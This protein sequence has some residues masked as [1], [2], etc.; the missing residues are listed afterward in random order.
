MARLQID[1]PA[2]LDKGAQVASHYGVAYYPTTILVDAQ[3]VVRAVWV[4][5]AGVRAISAG[6]AG[7]RAISAGVARGRRLKPRLDGLRAA[8]SAC[9]DWQPGSDLRRQVLWRPA[10]RL[11]ARFQPPRRATSAAHALSRPLLSARP[12]RLTSGACYTEAA[13]ALCRRAVVSAGGGRGVCRM[14]SALPGAGHAAPRIFISHSHEDADFCLKL[15]ADLRARLGDDAVWYDASGGQH[16]LQGG[17]AWWDQIVAEIT[18]RPYFLVVLSPHASASRWVP[19]EMGIAFRQHVELGKRLLPVRLAEAPRRA[20]WAGIQEFSFVAPR[21]YE[22]AL[23]DLLQALNVDPQQQAAPPSASVPAPAVAPALTPQQALLRRLTQEAHTAYGRERWS[24]TLDRT[25]ALIARQ[26]MTP[27]LWRERAS[28]ALAL[29]DSQAALNAVGQAL[30]DD[31]DDIETLRLHARI[32]LRAGQ[33][34]RAVE[35]LT[36]ANTL[37][38]LDDAATRLPLLAE[39]CD[40]LERLSRWGDLLRRCG[41]ALYLAP[42]DLAWQR[43]RLAALLGLNQTA[44]A[45]SAAQ[46]LAARAD[47]TTADHLALARLLKSSGAPEA[48]IRSA[49]DAATR[50]S[51]ADPAAAQALAQARGELLAPPPP[52]IPAERFPARLAALGFSAQARDGVEWIIP[53][54]C[55][56]PAGQFRLGSD[57][58]RDKDARDSDELQRRVVDL[59]AFEIARFPVTVAEY[60]CFLTA[61]QRTPPPKGQYNALTWEDQLQRLDHPVV[62]VT[63][64]DAYD[65]AAWLAERTQ[66]SPGGY[67]PRR[68]GRRRRVATHVTRWARAANASTPGATASRWRAATPA[69]AT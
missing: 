4:G 56:V 42:Q 57:K 20:D 11:E 62:G 26:A 38:P 5:V 60:A 46:T 1:A 54:V 2:L 37:A 53:P 28:A 50:L 61:T 45:L 14:S 24:D 10:G 19:Q 36:L 15:V 69:R 27:A 30:Q 22:Q 55:L 67:Q 68:S 49:L 51:G 3:G 41:D 23:A 31:P 40:A 59:P 48:P 64:Y 25:D 17:E 35:A 44:D 43:R 16:G 7:V 29:G 9:A 18:A 58:R 6:V 8:K 34:E 21:T 12:A 47:A 13:S 32:L 33:S 65:Y 63:W 52:P 39:L 66:A